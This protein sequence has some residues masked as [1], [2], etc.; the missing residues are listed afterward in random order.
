MIYKSINEI[1][2]FAFDDCQVISFEIKGDKAVLELEALVVLEGNSQND[3]CTKSYAGTTYME[4]E[5]VSVEECV[6]IGYKKYDANNNLVEQE[7]DEK[8]GK[9]AIEKLMRIATET[10]PAFLTLVSANTLADGS[11]LYSLEFEIPRRIKDTGSRISLSWKTKYVSSL[12]QG[13]S[14]PSL[15]LP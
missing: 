13:P 7:E 4:I 2:K 9:N 6:R 11:G 15:W 14:N 10:E 3:N 12:I 5:A 1:D 8:L